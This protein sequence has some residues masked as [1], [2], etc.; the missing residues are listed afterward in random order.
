MHDKM[1]AQR[2]VDA[3]VDGALVGGR[4]VGQQASAPSGGSGRRRGMRASMTLTT[5]PIAE[6]PNSRAEGPRST[7]IFSAVIGLMAMAW[8]G[9]DEPMSRLPMPSVRT[10]T[11]SPERPRST[12][13]EAAGPKLVAL[14]PGWRAWVSPM[15]GRTSR[16]SS[17]LSS[18]DTPPS[19]SPAARRTPVTT[20]CSSSS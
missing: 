3:E 2:D 7:S 14:T 1:A 19:P 18:T 13:A 9:P 6:E 11:R 4:A 5:P 16:V 15:L 17:A 8:S 12:G 20:S 10:R